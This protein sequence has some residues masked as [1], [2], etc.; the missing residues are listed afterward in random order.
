VSQMHQ[1]WHKDHEGSTRKMAERLA[2]W[3][4]VAGQEKGSSA[5]GIVYMLIEIVEAVAVA[6]EAALDMKVHTMNA[7]LARAKCSIDWE[8]AKLDFRGD[9]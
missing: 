1:D 9:S 8:A 7:A 4:V 5:Q 6:A 2:S 3:L